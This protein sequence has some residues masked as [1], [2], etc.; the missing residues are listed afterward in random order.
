M[1][2]FIVCQ[3]AALNSLASSFVTPLS[4]FP[5]PTSARSAKIASR[6]T[7]YD[8][9]EEPAG[10]E[11]LVQLSSLEGARM[12]C[13]GEAEGITSEDGTV[14]KIW[15]M[16]TADGKLTEEF[17]AQILKESKAKASTRNSFI[18]VIGSRTNLMIRLT[19]QVSVRCVSV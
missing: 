6:A 8:L 17:R 13:M 18:Q 16:A 14:H 15:M 2:W 4:S 11:E 9:V 1:R 10:G 5:F 19:F 3:I 7:E 12:K